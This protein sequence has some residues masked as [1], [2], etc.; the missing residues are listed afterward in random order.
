M[1]HIH[2]AR[3]E[4]KLG[5][6]AEEEVQEGLRTG[7]FASTDL[8]WREGMAN[9]LPLAQME[10]STGDAPPPPGGIPPP[11]AKPDVQGMG[12]LRR[13]A[14]RGIAARS[15][16]FSPPSSKRSNSSCSIPPLHSRP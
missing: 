1:A 10:F 5:I 12:R 16:A 2:I 7:R 15:L 4:T 11:N 8:A 9:W 3:G 6:F 14:C 13:P